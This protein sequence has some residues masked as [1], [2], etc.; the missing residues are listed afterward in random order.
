MAGDY[1]GHQLYGNQWN[2]VIFGAKVIPMGTAHAVWTG[3]GAAGTFLVGVFVY[4]DASSLVR[5]LGVF[6]ILSGVVLLK[7]GH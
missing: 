6:L 1:Y 5:Y 2:I 3:I 7:V 4:G